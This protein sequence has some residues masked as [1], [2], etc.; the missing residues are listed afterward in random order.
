MKVEQN[1]ALGDL[2]DA[3]SGLPG[4]EAIY[5]EAATLDHFPIGSPFGCSN[6]RSF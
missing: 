5:A 6:E 1:K 4:L 2:N 3:E